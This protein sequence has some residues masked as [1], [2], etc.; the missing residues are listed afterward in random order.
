MVIAEAGLTI[1]HLTAV[2]R[3]QGRTV[4]EITL[5]ID[6]EASRDL[7]D[8]IDQ[9][10][11]ARILGKSDRVFNRHRGGKIKTVASLSINTLQVLRDVYT[12]GVARVCLAIKTDPAAAHDFTNLDIT[13]AVV[14]N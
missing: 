6:E 3:G 5:E 2:R 10:P 12:P 14:T 11:I 4:W 7:Y 8:R 13:V 9:L 1:E